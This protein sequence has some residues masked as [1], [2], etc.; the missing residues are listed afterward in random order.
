VADSRKAFEKA[1][2]T[3]ANEA[4]RTILKAVRRNQRRVLVG[5]DAY[6]L[7]LLVRF[8]PAGSQRLMMAMARRM[9]K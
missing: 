9:S 5:L 6:A 1:F 4:A 3:S 7:D 2:I 8:A